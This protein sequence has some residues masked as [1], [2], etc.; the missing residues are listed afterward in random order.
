MQHPD[1]TGAAP[2]SASIDEG[3]IDSPTAKGAI[4]NLRGAA[5]GWFDVACIPILAGRDVQL[6]DTAGMKAIPVV[7]GSDFAKAVWGD[8]S[9]IG[10]TIGAPEL[11]N[12]EDA[13]MTMTVVGV[14]DATQ[15]IP[16]TGFQAPSETP[17]S[18]AF[19]ARDKRWSRDRVLVTTRPAGRPLIDDLRQLFARG[20]RRSRSR[21][22]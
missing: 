20:R 17:T 19:T 12:T 9:P 16:G 5:P 22:S 2:Y 6:A 10:R 21:G 8:A 1:V 7:I 3:R 11:R 18:R 13:E 14:Y 15:R 4:V